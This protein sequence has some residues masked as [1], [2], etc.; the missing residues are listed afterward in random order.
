MN[1]EDFKEFF[2]EAATKKG[3]HYEPKG[4][5]DLEYNAF[6]KVI[7]NNLEELERNGLVE[8]RSIHKLNRTGKED[9]I[10]YLI[11]SEGRDWLSKHEGD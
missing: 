5:S 1:K 11:T 9:K 10:L 7:E 4:E 2:I 6:L 3:M 8:I